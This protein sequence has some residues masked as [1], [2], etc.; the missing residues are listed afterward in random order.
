MFN[1]EVSKDSHVCQ[2]V[3]CAEAGVLSDRVGLARV[4]FQGRSLWKWI[5]VEP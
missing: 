3:E 5:W 4:V 1:E 2:A